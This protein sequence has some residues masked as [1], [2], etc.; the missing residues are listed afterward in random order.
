MVISVEEL[1]G[2]TAHNA[3]DEEKELECFIDGYLKAHWDSKFGGCLIPIV[4]LPKLQKSAF[5]IIK[6]IYAKYQKAGYRIQL[7]GE[8]LLFR[9][10]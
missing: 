8:Y 5:S 1:D 10:K 9:G 2:M 4:A 7:V 3:R 6:D